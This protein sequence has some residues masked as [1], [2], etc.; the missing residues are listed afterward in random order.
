MFRRLL[1]LICPAICMLCGTPWEDARDGTPGFGPLPPCRDCARKLITPEGLYCPRCG[2]KRLVIRSTDGRPC[3]RCRTTP[4]QFERAVVLGEY[5]SELRLITL[6]MKTDRSGLLAV[7]M[8]ALLFREREAAI[9][10]AA[11]DLIVP[12]P[13]H[14]R[15]R[16]TR[17][18][19]SPDFLAEELARFLKRP[20]AKHLVRRVRETE[21]QY[22]LSNR[23]RKANVEDAFALNGPGRFPF[24]RTIPAIGDRNILLVDD[25][26][27]SGATCN[28]VARILR[29]AGARSV[30]VC[31]VAR[32]EGFFRRNDEPETLVQS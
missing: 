17:G 10:A 26:L 3:R 1:D 13:I 23:R 20:V 15:R 32:A 19:N 21:L 4:F 22:I 28:E 12:V 25:I 29:Q 18:V 8:A 14:R 2:G 11:P 31:A 6:R 16:R 24:L 5:E 9:R 7:A 27:T 30:T